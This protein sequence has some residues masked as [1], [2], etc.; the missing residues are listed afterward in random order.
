MSHWRVLESPASM[1]KCTVLHASLTSTYTARAHFTSGVTL[2]RYYIVVTVLSGVETAND[3]RAG[4]A[5][6]GDG[7]PVGE[8]VTHG[9]GLWRVRKSVIKGNKLGMHS[10]LYFVFTHGGNG[11]SGVGGNLRR[12]NVEGLQDKLGVS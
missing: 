1:S 9:S 10:N 4:V 7:E 3:G 2:T 5:G 6:G 11:G 12:G 8:A